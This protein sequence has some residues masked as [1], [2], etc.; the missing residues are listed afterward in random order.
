MNSQTIKTYWYLDG[1]RL[2]MLDIAQLK[3]YMQLTGED[4]ANCLI[5]SDL[6]VRTS[7]EHYL[8]NRS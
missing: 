8:K 4:L 1:T 6:V 3:K 7:A 5:S 2:D